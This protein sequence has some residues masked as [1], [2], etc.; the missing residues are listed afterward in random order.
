MATN[1]P[2]KSTSNLEATLIPFSNDR[3]D[4]SF[5]TVDRQGRLCLSSKLRKDLG[6]IG[7]NV[8]MYVSYDKVNKRIGLAKPDIV[9][10]TN[11]RPFTFDK[12]RGYA[13]ARN[14]LK[15]AAISYNEASRYVYDGVEGDGWM[16]FKL[17][18]YDA[19]DKPIGTAE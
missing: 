4:T 3:A 17:A 18:D 5:I 16:T 15:A 2:A 8:A 14:F 7:N 9:R 10:L 13:M 6:N 11:T 1:K 12:N 19:P